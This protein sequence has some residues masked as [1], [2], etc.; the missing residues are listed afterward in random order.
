MMLTRVKPTGFG[1]RCRGILQTCSLVGFLFV[2]GTA[3]GQA[4]TSPSSD[5]PA[6]K[7]DN[8]PTAQTHPHN[9][10]L[11]N[12]DQMMEDAV[13]QIARRYNLN[14][15]QENFTRLLLVGRVRA[16]LDEHEGE[17]RQL[18]TENIELRLNP[19]KA[20]PEAYK[21][22]AIKALPVY[23][24]AQEAIFAGNEEWR[25]ILDEDQKKL[26]DQDLAQMRTNFDQVERTL[27][28]WQRGEG[29]AAPRRS[30]QTDGPDGQAGRLSDP[31]Q[32]GVVRSQFMED[33]WL[34]YVN[35][36]IQAYKLDEKMANAARAKIHKEALAQAKAYR[37]K[38]EREFEAIEQEMRHPSTDPEK[39]TKPRELVLRKAGLER[40]IRTMFVKMNERLQELPTSKQKNDVDAQKQQQ[41]INLF[42]MLSGE[43]DPK[44]PTNIGATGRPDPKAATTAPATAP[45]DAAPTTTKPA[46]VG[47]EKEQPSGEKATPATQKAEVSAEA[48]KKPAAP[49]EAKDGSAEEDS[50]GPPQPKAEE[51]SKPV[52]VGE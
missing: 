1:R 36:F 24:A 17:V 47:P 25:E 39:P 3:Y 35:L 11:W 37:E 13:L 19:A 44:E 7:Q 26:H 18:L 10:E 32:G 50:G 45:A 28:Q 46:A 2:C 20:T 51:P 4:A 12:V 29:L 31:Q 30:L 22:W 34:A 40:P 48:P 43:Y 49:P 41:L 23:E 27:S 5:P 52:E 38:H 8:Q 33:N 21:D 42:K 14:K 16:F 6:Q 15:A 9:P